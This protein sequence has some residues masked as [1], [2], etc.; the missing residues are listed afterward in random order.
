[1]NT[2]EDRIELLEDILIELLSENHHLL[3]GGVAFAESA[4]HRIQTARA[5]EPQGNSTP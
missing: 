1:M 3:V 4:I 5:A 2:L